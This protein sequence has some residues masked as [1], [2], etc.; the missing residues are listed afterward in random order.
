MIRHALRH[1]MAG[2]L[3]CA[4]AFAAPSASAED[5]YGPLADDPSMGG[6]LEMGLLV[7]PPGLDPFHQAAD[8]RIRLSLL[9]YQGLFY[10]GVGG[11][12]IPLL[13]ESYEVSDD[14]LTYTIKLRE[15]VTFHTGQ[16]MSAEDVAY[17]YNYIRD[18]AN[19]SPGAGDFSMIESV[20]AIDP[21]TVK[22]MLSVPNA[23]LPMTLGN[24][25]GAVVPAGYFDTEGA[26]NRMNVE[27]VGTG[28][29][30]LVEFNPNSNLL[31]E[32]NPDYW[33]EGAPYL[34]EINFTFLPNSASMLVALRNGRIDLVK[35]ERP[36]DVQQVATVPGLEVERWASLNQKPID[37]GAET[38]PLDDVRVRQAIALAVDKEE[39]KNA[40]V[41]EYGEVIAAMP[42]G[43]ADGWGVPAEDLPNMSRDLEKAKALLEEAGYGDGFDL[44]LTTINGYDWMDPAAVTLKQQLA[45][46]G[47]NL[48]IQRVD[49][50]V[51]IDNFR[52]KHM[53]FTFNDWASQP[54]PNLLFYRHFHKQPEGADFRN[55]NNDEASAL[56]DAGRAESD[57]AKRKAIYAEFQKVLAESVPTIMLFS[58]DHV[59]VRNEKVKNFSQH[60]TGWYFG[61]V[62]TYVDE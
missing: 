49:I 29:F 20:E 50:G 46:I 15:G 22:F 41:G 4:T 28:P 59:T 55:W 44:T 24:K 30:K 8:A 17:S 37:L 18:P 11:E 13:A 32:K 14:G 54:D 51:W 16:P 58:A 52:S 56:L 45:E 34:D 12:A 9:M 33:E 61:L 48:N 5:L 40:S 23:S 25:Y 27:S 21:T 36:Q 47:I 6:T 57:P 39:I 42:A 19:G 3:L 62:R 60:P 53:G 31:L 10:E 38:K 1:A 43:M 2:A 35:L 7:E 26:Q